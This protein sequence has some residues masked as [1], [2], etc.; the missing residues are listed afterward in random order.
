MAFHLRWFLTF[1]LLVSHLLFGYQFFLLEHNK[2][3][4]LKVSSIYILFFLVFSIITESELPTVCRNQVAIKASSKRNFEAAS[5]S[6]SSHLSRW[7][8]NLRFKMPNSQTCS[9]RKIFQV[10]MYILQFCLL[11]FSP[12]CWPKFTEKQY[13]ATTKHRGDHSIPVI[14]GNKSSH[15]HVL[16]QQANTIC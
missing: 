11:L 13:Q 15:Y 6:F 4:P 10:C 2:F 16:Y 14:Q 8:N 12:F 5:W 1:W 3:W 7:D 9:S